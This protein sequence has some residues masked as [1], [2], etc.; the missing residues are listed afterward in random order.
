MLSL[1]TPYQQ[2]RAELNNL[3]DFIITEGFI[4]LTDTERH[5]HLEKLKQLIK[6][7]I[8]GEEQA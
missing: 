8:A 4:K 3:M 2:T 6:A 7:T 1:L 5:Q